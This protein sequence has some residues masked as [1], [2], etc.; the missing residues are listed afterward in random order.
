MNV[1]LRPFRALLALSLRAKLILGNIAIATVAILAIGYL[2][3]SNT[4]KSNVY[5]TGQLT[6]S[7][8]QR[9]EINLNDSTERYAGDLD[10]FFST[11]TNS[12]EILGL[13]VQA[14]FEQE[15]TLGEGSTWDARQKLFQ[16]PTGSWDNSNQEAGSIFLPSGL[17][18]DEI[19][20]EVNTLKQ[21]DALAP[22]LLQS[23][24][25]LV[26][27]YFGGVKGETV[28]YP[29]IDLANVVPPD[30]DI[31]QRLW[32]VDAAPA[33]NKDLGVVWSKPYLDAANNGMVIT[34]SMPIIDDHG[35]FRGVVAMDIKLTDITSL[36]STIRYGNTGYAFL[37]DRKGGLIAISEAGYQDFS[38][39]ADEIKAGTYL[40]MNLL[41]QV[42]LGDAF[43]ILTKM[44]S[45]QTGIRIASM[46]GVQKYIAY[47]PIPSVGYSLGI[48][49]DV[50]E[51]QKNV[52][53][54]QQQSAANE[55]GTIIN[56]AVVMI[57][58]WVIFLFASRAL[59]NVLT[60]PLLELTKNAQRIIEG[61]LNADLRSRSTDEVGILAKTLETMTDNLRGVINETE[62]RVV[63]RTTDLEKATLESEKRAQEL[64]TISEVARAISSE[65]NLENLLTLIT[66]L[67][68][69][70]FGFY[71]VGVFLIDT[72]TKYAVLRASNSP[73]GKRMIERGHK[74]QI[75]QVGIVGHAAGTGEARI[76]LDVGD[77]A[78]YFDNP[79]LP[80]TRSE[81]ALPL[82]LRGRV[83]GILDVQST[84]PN[85]FT[86]ADIETLGI[87]ADQI[88]IAIDNARLLAESQQA[89]AEVQALYGEYIGRSWERKTAKTP[90]G[91]HHASVGSNS[92]M[93]PV[94][95]D[96]ARDAMATGKT[97]VTT[98]QADG[99][100]KG[101]ISAVAVPIRIQNQIIGVID[102]RSANPN[103]KWR[104]DEIAVIEATAERLALALENAR[105]FE[106][107]STRAA[108]EHTVA[109]ISS[110]IRNTND[111][112]VMIRTAIEELQRAL[113]VTRVEII[114]QIVTSQHGGNA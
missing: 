66:Y 9:A 50:S 104:E 65:V 112:Q 44:A 80:N 92:L 106:E 111:P 28:Y 5:L 113:G 35:V 15:K 51:T 74:L 99:E 60:S 12:M 68:S 71:H 67:V 89:L 84:E 31:T 63:E 105:L 97:L 79:D 53:E 88:A 96:E 10:E 109:E 59:G 103:R 2:T 94:G 32:Y 27:L 16:L 14:V 83:I 61:D 42:P 7:E 93:E 81:M 26:A 70:R 90:I 1:L 36:I 54:A 43:N 22:R 73:G 49:V 48:V 45:S 33:Q 25:N 29:N 86:P 56:L 85:A 20:S 52:T 57:V 72:V 64:E 37:I 95:W 47:H 30:F 55:R 102:I 8:L 82:K 62:Q 58:V 46:N 6:N 34:C 13:N 100:N 76:A 110:K 77:D 3:I 39:T 24:P 38:I 21:L 108:R 78:V 98:S 87:L 41:N 18:P 40:D 69:E 107:T 17:T 19:Y 4:A 114:P 91:Y 75:G 101:N 11:V 23:N